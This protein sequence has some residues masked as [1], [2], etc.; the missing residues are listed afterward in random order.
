MPTTT[1]KNMRRLPA[2]IRKQAD[3]IVYIPTAAKADDAESQH[4]LVTPTVKGTFL[5][6]WTQAAV[7]NAPNQGVVVSRSLGK[8]GE[9]LF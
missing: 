1:R 6:V 2:L 7:G 9:P 8:G 3:F 5:A 4:F